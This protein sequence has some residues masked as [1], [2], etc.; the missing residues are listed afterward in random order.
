MRF[1]NMRRVKHGA[2]PGE[3]NGLFML[4]D[5]QRQTQALRLL[6]NCNVR[7][8]P[9]GHAAS[10]RCLHVQLAP[11][12]PPTAEKMEA[13]AAAMM[14]GLDIADRSMFLKLHRACFLG[15]DAV[16]FLRS[17]TPGGVRFET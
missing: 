8:I 10:W 13:V 15:Q 14:R 17:N 1:P 7:T 12:R 3:F 9:L 4:T 5:E 6:A 16:V 2:S 11:V